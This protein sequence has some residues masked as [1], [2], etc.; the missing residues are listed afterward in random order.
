MRRVLGVIALLAAAAT[1]PAGAHDMLRLAKAQPQAFSF[2]PFNVG[3]E[4]GI[5]DR[6][7]LDFIEV[8]VGGSAKLQQ[9]LIANAVDIGLGSGPELAFIAK[10]SSA[11]GIAAMA[12]PPLNLSLVVQK[13]GPVKAIADLKGKSLAVSTAGGLTEWLA[14]ELSRQQGWGPDG[15]KAVGLGATTAM[16]AAMKTGQTDG[17]VTDTGTAIHLESEGTGRTLL[18]F[19]HIVRNFHVHVIY[20]GADAMTKRPDAVRRFLAG[21]FE[22]IAYMRVNKAKILPIAGKVMNTDAAETSK[23]SDKV[24]PMFSADGKFDAKALAVLGNSFVELGTLDAL[25]DMSKTYTEQFLPSAA[26]TD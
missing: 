9:A 21:W 10:G 14:R 22:T 16:V 20:A 18:D 3:V 24:M 23:I 25:P 1:A 7:D 6:L 13:D 19:G 15:V 11:R 17:I 2:V 26:K 5:F 8:T 12:G 4:T